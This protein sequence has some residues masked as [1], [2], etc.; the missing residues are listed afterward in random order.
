MSYPLTASKLQTY[1]RCPHAY[2]LQYE[3]KLPGK[4]GFG[5]ASAVGTAV[6]EALATMYQ[7]WHYNDPMPDLDWVH[8]C[9]EGA[10][11]EGLNEAQMAEGKD[12]LESYYQN[13]VV[14]EGGMRRPVGTEGRLQGTLQANNLEFKITGRYDR[15]DCLEDGALEVIDYKSNREVKL[16]DPTSIDIQ[17]GVYYLALQQTYGQILRYLSLLFLRTGEK[18]QFEATPDH[19]AQVTEIITGL[20]V[21]LREEQAWEPTPGQQ[22]DRC[23]Y[24]PY[25]PAMNDEPQPVPGE[26]PTRRLQLALS[27]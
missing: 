12:L 8:R 3:R 25:C 27:L 15:L 1:H 17:L 21:Q 13:F 23:Q 10:Q 6:H 22:C 5:G 19:K 26:V 14:E 20:A 24:K 18:V 2:Y 16:P 7:Q 9:W 11:T 4:P